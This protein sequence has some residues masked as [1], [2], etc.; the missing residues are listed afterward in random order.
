MTM[1]CR[2]LSFWISPILPYLIFFRIPHDLIIY[3]SMIHKIIYKDYHSGKTKM[4]IVEPA[5]TPTT[6]NEMADKYNSLVSNSGS[7]NELE[8]FLTQYDLLPSFVLNFFRAKFASYYKCHN[9]AA[10]Y[11]NLVIKGIESAT[12]EDIDFYEEHL[13]RDLCKDIYRYAGEVYANN[14]EP[15][16][17]LLYYQD[18]QLTLFHIKPCDY[19][20]G[21]LSF[22]TFNEYTLSDL[23]NN[24]ITVCSPRVMNDPYDTLLIKWGECIRLRKK[25]KKHVEALC[26]SFESYRI[27]SFCRL[28][29]KQGGDIVSNVLMWAHY[30]NNHKGFCIKYKFSK[31]FLK[32]ES[33]CVTRFKDIIY[34]DRCVPFN[35]NRHSIN[36]DQALCTKLSDWAYENE[37]R[38]ITCAPDINGYFLTI[39]IDE[40]SSI[41]EVYFGYRCSEET[42]KTV[43]N[44]LSYVSGIKYF[45]MSSDYKDIYKLKATPI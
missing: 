37:V 17:A 20:E 6:Y 19:S 13:N 34:H 23:V 9:E 4:R 36:T 18:Y 25:G 8:A 14:D 22:R 42:I 39:P 31:G 29:D 44:A 32:T 7:K 28:K 24:E 21:L 10:K 41:D 1:L 45:K 12:P 27:R 26:Q 35:M 40:E 15:D 43:R 2:N 33:R 11:M 30:A 5:F 38:L 16:K 3:K